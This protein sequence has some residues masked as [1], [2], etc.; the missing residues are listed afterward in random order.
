MQEVAFFCYLAISKLQIF[1][2]MSLKRT[3]S[4]IKDIAD[5]VPLLE[6]FYFKR[7][8][9][10]IDPVPISIKATVVKALRNSYEIDFEI[11]DI[12]NSEDAEFD[13]V[14]SDTLSVFKMFFS[15]LV[16]SKMIDYDVITYEPI[17]DNQLIGWKASNVKIYELNTCN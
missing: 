15:G 2:K 4:Q 12:V 5:S 8:E 16:A 3:F 17:Q 11:L 6:T 9:D 14:R 10:T 7:W 13:D 1:N